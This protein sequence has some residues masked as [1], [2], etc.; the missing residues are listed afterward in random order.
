[1]RS[2]TLAVF[3]SALFVGIVAWWVMLHVNQTTTSDQLQ[4]WAACY[5]VIAFVGAIAGLVISSRWGGVRSVTG[6]AILAFSI[7]LLFQCFGQS[8]YSFYIY[9][10]NQPIPYP[11]IGDIGFFGSIPCYLYGSYMLAKISGASFRQSYVKSLSAIILPLLLLGFS[12]L[13]FLRD[14]AFDWTQPLKIFLDFGYPFGQAIYISAAIL[15]VSLSWRQLGGLMR[16]PLFVFAIAL[17]AQYISD[18]TFL[19][20]ANHGTYYAGGIA[21]LMYATAYFLMTL[22]II[23]IG[24][25]YNTIRDSK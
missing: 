15:A 25:T 4:L 17:L 3:A 23:Y 18:F 14:Y 22:A 24:Q 6:R 13:I 5:Q 12:Y 16:L 20:R 10:L 1:M 7:G 21:D 2:N 9:F 19:F 11:S 8:A